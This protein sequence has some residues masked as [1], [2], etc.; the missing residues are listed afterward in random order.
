MIRPWRPQNSSFEYSKCQYYSI[1]IFKFGPQN[2]KY[3]FFIFYCAQTL[4]SWFRKKTFRAF[5]PFLGRISL[6]ICLRSSEIRVS[7]LFIGKILPMVE[8]ISWNRTNWVW[9]TSNGC[10]EILGI[11]LVSYIIEAISLLLVIL[12]Y[13]CIRASKTSSSNSKFLSFL[14]ILN[15]R[16]S[17]VYILRFV[18]DDIILTWIRRCT[19]YET[20]WRKHLSV[21]W[22]HRDI[23]TRTRTCQNGIPGMKERK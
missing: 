12:W 4:A 20:R 22:F 15:I 18:F 19:K 9:Q 21:R 5:T 17:S 10:R 13:K 11:A 14:W 23:V 6:Q 3:C 2:L 16:D 1:Y 7:E 8:I